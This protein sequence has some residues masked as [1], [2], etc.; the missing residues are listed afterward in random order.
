[1]PLKNLDDA[2]MDEE[3]SDSDSD[4]DQDEDSAPGPSN[5]ASTSGVTKSK[6]G[7]Y[8][9]KDI[10]KGFARIERDA[11]GNVL[12]V[13][14]SAFDEP[15]EEEEQE[16]DEQDEEEQDTPWGK[17]LNDGKHEKAMQKNAQPVI[18]KNEAIR[19]TLHLH[20]L[21]ALLI[22]IPCRSRTTNSI[23]ERNKIKHDALCVPSRIASLTRACR[24]V[25]R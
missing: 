5:E 19:S 2:Q 6:S 13:V 22:L 8:T 20:T 23:A 14:M 11:E 18:A 21:L 1:V 16:G 24:E 15:A 10:P 17:P 25:W 3:D 7:T 12:R 9:S 4:S